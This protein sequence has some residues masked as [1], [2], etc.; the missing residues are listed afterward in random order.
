MENNIEYVENKCY[1]CEKRQLGCHS[2]CEDYKKYKKY[3]EKIRAKERLGVIYREYQCE[4]KE[5]FLRNH[6]H[7]RGKD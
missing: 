5:K 7:L 1:G 4:R 2:K 6:S 3:L